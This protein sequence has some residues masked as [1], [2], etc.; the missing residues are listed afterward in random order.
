MR[1]TDIIRST[2]GSRFDQSQN[3]HKNFGRKSIRDCRNEHGCRQFSS[4]GIGKLRAMLSAPFEHSCSNASSKA[5]DTLRA[6]R[7]SRFGRGGSLDF[8]KSISSFRRGFQKSAFCL[9]FVTDSASILR[10]HRR[11]RFSLR[12][13]VST[14]RKCSYMD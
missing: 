2:D 7:A 12:P 8:D 5:S 3:S 4:S 13:S 10:N 1:L 6:G 14:L 9:F 11:F